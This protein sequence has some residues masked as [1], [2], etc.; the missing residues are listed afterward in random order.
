MNHPLHKSIRG[1]FLIIT[2]MLILF[3]GI[4]V[5]AL[6][7]QMFSK[8]L[9][10]NLIHT[11]E[12]NL[13][14][15]ASQIDSSLNEIINLT[16]W[17]RNNSQITAFVMTPKSAA[18]YN[19]V[20][21]TAAARLDEE[22]RTSH[23]SKYLCRLVISGIERSDYLQVMANASYSVDRPIPSIVQKLSYYHRLLEADSYDFGIGFQ[24]DPFLSRRPKMLPVIRPVIHPYRSSMVGFVYA[25]VSASLFADAVSEY[26][27]LEDTC[28]YFTS[29]DYSY[30]VTSDG[31]APTDALKKLS[32]H[33]ADIPL[34]QNISIH[35]AESGRQLFL[36]IPLA[37]R[38]CSLTLPVSNDAF[39]GQAG[40]YLKIISAVFLL[41]AVI[42]IILICSLFHIV[43]RPVHSIRSRLTAISGG[44]FS[45]DE[46]IEWDNEF[47]D[48]GKA[49]NQLAVS[50]HS[51]IEAKIA[52]EKQKKDYEYQVLQSQINPHFL[53]NTLN[54]MKWMASAQNAPGIAE[55]ATALS[56]LLKNISKG[57]STIVSIQD[58]I[59]LLTDYFTIQKYRYGGTISLD[60]E[61]D[62]PALLSNQILRF[63]LQPV[64]ENAIFHGIEP[65][66]Q[67]GRITIHICQ[68]ADTDIRIDITDNGVG[69]TQET[70]ARVLSQDST[71]KSH[72]FRQIGISSVNR[73]IQ[74]TFGESYGLTIS[75]EP[76]VYTSMSIRLPRRNTDA[77]TEDKAAHSIHA[78]DKTVHGIHAEDKTAHGIHAENRT[79]HSIHAENKTAHHVQAEDDYT[80]KKTDQEELC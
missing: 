62:D 22:F 2:L 27:K 17:C 18:N 69:M 60:Y 4:S 32:P 54:S 46:T 30:A 15:F 49:V 8:N 35:K 50:I 52:Y 36:T 12:T 6:S 3:V 58:E 53:Y 45:K 74:Y 31:I 26:I 13:Q 56:H 73:Q 48:I 51:L 76:G 42:G 65:K 34:N 20:T 55:M 70:I 24:E 61:I 71:E 19:R 57:T 63:T 25:E 77:H 33:H 47:G 41:S 80:D 64:V 23:S 28:I 40:G 43:T 14:L 11:A 16:D 5:S 37:A 68:S 67:A 44:D 9:T 59:T 39:R 1:R 10:N 79:V 78:E 21:S 38:G 29:G 7:Y 66:G 75:S 72:F